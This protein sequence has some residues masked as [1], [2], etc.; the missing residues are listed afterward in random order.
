MAAVAP[1]PVGIL[2]L[3]LVLLFLFRFHK[4]WVA[5]FNRAVTNRITRRFAVR[6]PG[7]GIVIHA[8]RMSSRIYRT[9]VNVFR[10]PDGFVIAL[11]YGRD[12]EWVKNVLAAH[13]CA[14]E[15]RRVVYR[16]S[17]PVVVHDPTLRRFP[18]LVRAGLRVVGATDYLHL[19]ISP[20]VPTANV[21]R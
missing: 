21:G 15:T 17:T 10:L 2:F 12:S 7:F 9:P 1:L 19:S 8:G 14:L 3:L 16:L 6:L 11:T 13:G 18:L 20:P 4:R 5:A